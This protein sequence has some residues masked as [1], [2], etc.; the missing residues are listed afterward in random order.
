MHKAVGSAA[1]VLCS[2]QIGRN[3]ETLLEERHK[4]LPFYGCD[5]CT[6][7][8]NG[9][10]SMFLLFVFPVNAPLCHSNTNKQK[11]TAGWVKIYGVGFQEEG[12]CSFP[13]K[14]APGA[15]SW[16]HS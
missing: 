16:Q 9:F 5:K 4:N 2:L 14:D 13:R 7:I 10:P 8:H 6:T 15:P 1:L 3:E 11:N 12:V